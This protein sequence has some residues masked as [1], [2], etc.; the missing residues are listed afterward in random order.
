MFGIDSCDVKNE[1]QVSHVSQVFYK[2]LHGRRQVLI[3]TF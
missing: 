3:M 2:C 1:I